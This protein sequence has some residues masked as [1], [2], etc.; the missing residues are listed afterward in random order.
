MRGSVGVERTWRMMNGL[1]ANNTVLK[2]LKD[3]SD[4]V[5]QHNSSS[6]I[7]TFTIAAYVPANFPTIDFNGFLVVASNNNYSL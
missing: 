4:D 5:I 1:D 2:A 7:K 6:S 3:T